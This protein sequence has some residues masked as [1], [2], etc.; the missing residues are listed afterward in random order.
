MH[1]NPAEAEATLLVFRRSPQPYQACRYILEN[2]QMPNARFQAAATIQEAAIRE[3]GFLSMDEKSSL[4]MYCLR[5]I[6]AHADAPEGY[7]QVKVSS[8]AAVLMKRNWIEFVEAEKEAFF[9]EVKTAVQGAHGLPVQSTGITFLESLVS[10]FSPSTAS[11]MGLPAEFH[12]QCRTNLELYYLQQFYTWTQNAAFSVAQKAAQGTGNE[13]KVCTA[14]LRLMSQILNWDFKGNTIRVAGGVKIIGKNR[15]HIFSSFSGLEYAHKKSGEQNVVQPGPGW[16]DLLLPPDR[17]NWLLE[18]YAALRQNSSGYGSW[19]DSPLAVS[20]RHLIVQLCC[21]N[22]SIF[23]SDGGW[24]QEQHLQRMLSGIMSWVNPAHVVVSTI[25]SGKSESELIDGC[26]ALLS[27]ACLTAPT[28]FDQLLKGYSSHFSTLSLLSSLTCEVIKVNFDNYD[29]E[30]TWS[31]EALNILLDTWTVFLQVLPTGSSDK[32]PLSQLGVSALVAVFNTIVETELTVAAKLAYDEEDSNEKLQASIAVRDERLSSFALI[33]RSVPGETIALLAKLFSERCSLLIQSRGVRSDRTCILEELHW[34]LLISGHVLADSDDGE[35]PL[36]PETIQAQLSDIDPENHP[37]LVLSRSIIDLATHSLESNLREEIFSARLMEAVVWFLGRW[38]GTYLM[39]HDAG[40][41][42]TSILCEDGEMK[43]KTLPGRTVFLRVIG[44][45]NQG[46]VLLA[47]LVRVAITA[48]TSWP[49]EINLQEIVCFK[50]LC[51]LVRRR[52]ICI[53]LVTLDPWK[54]FANA[55][56]NERT[57]LSLPARLQRSLAESLC[58]SASGMSTSDNTNQY[59]RDLM[60]PITRYLI[61]MSKKSDLR[62]FAQNPDVIFLITCLVER[63]RGA[64]IATEPRNQRA[65]FEMGVSVMNSLLTFVEVYKNQSMVV[66]IL[67]KFVVDWVDGQVAFLEAK[68]TTILFN[69]CL[70]LLQIYSVHNI[71]K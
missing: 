63:L 1:I 3:W 13:V 70:R 29:E 41:G 15:T 4:I 57:L 11:A 62:V 31:Q 65:T 12:E 20:C 52:N 21:L 16:R 14:A 46:K 8:V 50:L 28:V 23:P 44:D 55:F 67:L 25:K 5:Y 39:P 7:V 37:V 59:V 49:G 54:E 66:Y 40:K 27:V 9:T 43:H 26:H 24:T 53:H 33:A 2:S 61:D 35:T 22:G 64:A 56:A 51:A 42:P 60:G 10:E 68:D 36:V 47:T 45:E 32:A 19:M 6:V 17:V 38:V 30:E 58:R 71:G 48:L 69:F 34:L 18:Y